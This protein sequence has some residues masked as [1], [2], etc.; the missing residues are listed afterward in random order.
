MIAGAPFIVMLAPEAT[1]VP[2]TEVS[3]VPDACGIYEVIT[4]T[5]VPL[6]VG[7]ATS[8]RRRLT[9]HARSR[10]SRLQLRVPGTWDNPSDVVSKQSVLA[11]H[12]FF[13]REIAPQYDLTTQDGRQRFLREQCRVRF[14]ITPSRET[15]RDL[16]RELEA[17]GEYRY[18]GG[19]RIRSEVRR[20]LAHDA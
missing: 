2:F 12:L 4:T 11:K 3:R 18:C 17:T 13:D 5:G 1:E 8:L 15:A 7:I 6:K 14:L 20:P 9:A 16:E 19:V 10:Q